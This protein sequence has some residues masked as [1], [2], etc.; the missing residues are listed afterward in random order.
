M[1]RIET[2]ADAAL[3]TGGLEAL[4]QLGICVVNDVLIAEGVANGHPVPATFQLRRSDG[5]SVSI[6][7]IPYGG[8]A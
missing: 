2:A 1:E 6:Y 8:A 5:R 4:P 7:T 3:A